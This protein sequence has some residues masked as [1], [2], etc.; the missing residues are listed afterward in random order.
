MPQ[1]SFRFKRFKHASY[2]AFASLNRVV[3]IGVLCM[4][5]APK[6]KRSV[7]AMWDKNTSSHLSSKDTLD[8]EAED[9]LEAINALQVVVC[10]P[11]KAL[12]LSAH[13]ALNLQDFIRSLVQKYPSKSHFSIY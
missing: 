6:L 5:V 12:A 4:D 3:S 13:P 8:L 7:K 10:P 9:L 11:V 2:A 1:S